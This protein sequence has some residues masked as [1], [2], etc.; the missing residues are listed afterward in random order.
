MCKNL[1]LARANYVFKKIAAK[2]NKRVEESSDKWDTSPSLLLFFS[3]KIK[4]HVFFTLHSSSKNF[5]FIS[6]FSHFIIFIHSLAFFMHFWIN[7]PSILFSSYCMYPRLPNDYFNPIFS[8]L[9]FS[10][11][12]FKGIGRM[13]RFKKGSR[14][15]AA[16][17]PI[18]SLFYPFGKEKIQ[19]FWMKKKKIRLENWKIIEP[20]PFNVNL[21][22]DM[23][24]EFEFYS[25]FEI[26]MVWLRI[27]IGGL[28]L[29]MENLSVK[30]RMILMIWD[31]NL[32]FEDWNM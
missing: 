22:W 26:W 1:P 23:G 5:C 10:G 29:F 31:R 28:R 20:D 9:L 17:V 11:L 6:I 8:W 3:I 27:F 19:K 12:K 4:L 13:E 18:F 21:L 25:L 15:D 16:V 7:F 32:M 24:L 14:V 30:E 2:W